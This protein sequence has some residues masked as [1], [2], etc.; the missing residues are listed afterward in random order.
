[1][2]VPTSIESIRGLPADVTA[3]TYDP[4][5]PIPEEHVDADALI[6][7]ANPPEQLADAAGRL[8]H[9]RW[10]Q[11]LAAGADAVLA[12][13]F[14]DSVVITNGIGLHNDAVAEHAMALILAAVR[15][16]DLCVLAATER[17]WRHDLR[18]IAQRDEHNALHTLHGAR[19]TIWGLGEIGGRLAE[20]LAVFGAHVVGLGR[21]AA[22]RHGIRVH[23]ADHAS[24][25][26]A[27]TDVLVMILPATSATRH[28]LS[29][30]LLERLPG[31]AWVVNVGRGE[32]VDEAALFSA[33]A[34]G[35]IGGAA[36]DVFEV[37]PLPVDSPLWG[38]DN[39]IITPHA[40]G[41]RPRGYQE[42]TT[43]NCAAFLRGFGLLNEVA[44]D[45]GSR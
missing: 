42:L 28:A 44:R 25:V 21:E 33:V 2:L 40:A 29:A 17:T 36:L 13:G 20:M 35:S 43:R 34:S 22:S 39:V 11:T 41:G 10:V 27:E 9:V 7:W 45:T 30:E 23:P 31:R 26:L 37:E 16:V 8:T 15:R 14:A 1:M 3:V 19:V 12:A 38:L 5:R 18:G 32:T 24:Q 6:V 4:R